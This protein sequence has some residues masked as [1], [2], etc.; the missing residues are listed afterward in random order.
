MAIAVCQSF[1]FIHLEY[2]KKSSGHTA[3]LLTIA[4]IEVFRISRPH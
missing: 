4:R 1:F 3:Y 2:L